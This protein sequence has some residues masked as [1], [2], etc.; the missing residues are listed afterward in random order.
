MKKKLIAALLALAFGLSAPA[1]V[2]AEEAA[3]SEEA[4]PPMYSAKCPSPCSFSVKSHDKAEVVA[5][6]QEHA[7]SHH[8]GM[9][10]SDADAAAMVK[11]SEPKK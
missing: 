1:L 8:K 10:L 3:K 5:I 11:V 7:K 2:R 4:K 9:A 6:L